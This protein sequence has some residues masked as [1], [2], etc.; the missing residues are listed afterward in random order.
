M[1]LSRN[2]HIQEEQQ[3]SIP[4]ET[5]S[6]LTENIVSGVT[7]IASGLGG[8]LDILPSNND[9]DEAEYQ[10]RQAL[11]RKKKKKKRRG[12]GL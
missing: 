6:K 4:K 8:L 9:S 7:D 1:E 10:H 2:N 5:S 3:V 12:M 11:N